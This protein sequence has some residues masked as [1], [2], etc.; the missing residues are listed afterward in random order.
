MDD[1]ARIAEGLTKAQQRWLEDAFYGA[2]GW[3]IV[4][5]RKKASQL[6]LCHPGTSLITPMGMSVRSYLMEKRN[7]Q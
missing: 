3:R 2:S 5:W 1:V 7:G 4:G 6:G